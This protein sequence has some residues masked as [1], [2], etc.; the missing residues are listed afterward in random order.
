MAVLSIRDVS[1]G[2]GEN[3]L[4]E[5]V[6]LQM[7]HGE[8]VCLVGRNGEGKSTL[9][10]LINGDI[11]PDE[12]EI[13]RRQGVVISCL[14]Q[15]VP[16]G[17]KGKVFDVVM[18]GL[19]QQSELL[20]KYHRVSS[21]LSGTDDHTLIDQLDRISQE[22]DTEWGWQIHTQVEKVISRMQLDPVAEFNDLSAG[23]KRRV[24]LARALVRDPDI[25]LLD[26]PT[27][28]LDIDAICWLEEFML[29]FEGILLFVTHDRMFLQKLATRII[30][31]DR[32]KLT[33]WSCDYET[34]LKRKEAVL[35][36]ESKEWALFDKKLA[37]EEAWIRRGVKARRTRNEGR[38]RALERMREVRRMRREFG[39]TVRLQ[40]QEAERSGKL[41]V[42]AEGVSF[43]YGERQIIRDFSTVIMRGDKV[44]IIGPNGSGKTTLLNILLGKL[45]PQRG[46]LR[47]GAH[48][49]VAYFDQLR[50]QLDEDKTVIENVGRG[51]NTVTI[52]GK[53]IH[54][55]GYLQNFLFSPERA[56]IP[57]SVLSGGERNR[58][59]LALLFTK[60]SNVL[61]MD[62]PTNDLDTETLELLE[63]LLLN[64]KGTLL[65]VSHD[66]TFL[67][68]VVTSTLVFEGEGEVN[69][70]VGGY[71]DWLRQR[72]E[73]T[74]PVR[75]EEPSPKSQKPR[76]QLQRPRK[77]SYKEQ[78]ELEGL[79][80]RI[81]TLESEQRRLYESMS[82]P[83]F[84][85][86]DREGRIA[87]AKARLNSLERELEE[88]YRRW[89][90]LEELNSMSDAGK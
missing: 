89:E 55:I 26:E 22:L 27:N 67:N 51:S 57:V 88:A 17:L 1:F 35:E 20:A 85:R 42:E 62:E 25:L 43:S 60:P 82:D 84:Y 29:G 7:E 33:S 50:E 68:N 73:D 36:A 28:H 79:P 87:E 41:V 52:N 49:E 75:K 12:G 10:K 76:T 15:E 44:G 11:V 4:L 23:L 78:R 13:T 18:G 46:S 14:P 65:L 39:G 61:V 90:V 69:E 70:Y 58:L 80:Q 54:I 2:F 3:L 5:K 72:K 40:A 48:L 47:Q 63:E 9:I 66:R 53:P 56:R 16:P 86:N 74:P 8:R 64:Y 37:Q 83:E 6:N 21:R 71:D 34:F 19:E 77:L 59:L 31:L 38:V 32:G 30:E 45:S 81:E 24:L